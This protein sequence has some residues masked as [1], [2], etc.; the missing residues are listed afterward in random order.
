MDA[1]NSQ[2]VFVGQ[3]L[4]CNIEGTVLT[5]KIDFSKQLGDS[6]SGKSVLIA[7]SNGIVNLPNG[8]AMSINAFR[9][10]NPRAVR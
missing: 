7:T 8:A 10:K 6:A 2:S 1:K 3:N 5:C 9:N 4:D